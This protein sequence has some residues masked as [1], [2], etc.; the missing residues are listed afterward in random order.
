[1][2]VNELLGKLFGKKEAAVS[3]KLP[4]VS[5]T[6]NRT[7]KEE[8]LYA[9]WLGTGRYRELMPFIRDAI[10]SK[11]ADQPHNLNVHLHETGTANG[12]FFCAHPGFRENDLQYIFEYFKDRVLDHD[13]FLSNR[14]REIDDAPDRVKT[15]ESYYLKPSHKFKFETPVNQLYGN[16]HLEYVAFDDTPEYVKVM[17]MNYNDRNYKAAEPFEDFLTFLFDV[18]GWVR[19]VRK[20]IFA[21]NSIQ[22]IK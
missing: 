8:W 7:Q 9:E 10:I 3:G 2:N 17:V 18:K 6:L 11:Q 14:L 1:M 5:E 15:T 4:L 20:P 13:Y 19:S 16:I 22:W 21:Q 12:F